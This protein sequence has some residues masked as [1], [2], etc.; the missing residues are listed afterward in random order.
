MSESLL[1]SKWL[2]TQPLL[3]K[4]TGIMLRNI[5]LSY[6]LIIFRLRDEPVEKESRPT[7]IETAQSH[8]HLAE[9][10]SVCLMA[11]SMALD[12]AAR[13]E[14]MPICKPVLNRPIV[15]A[16]LALTK[17]RCTASDHAPNQSWVTAALDAPVKTPEGLQV[18]DLPYLII[19]KLSAIRL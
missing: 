14:I 6:E 12:N 15:K 7:L 11:L 19:L 1:C 10:L 13:I 16:L 2:K 3:N 17:T 9:G 5:S 18:I 8:R 4:N